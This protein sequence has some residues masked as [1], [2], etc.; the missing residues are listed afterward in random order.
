LTVVART[1]AQPR[2]ARQPK[3]ASA[4]KRIDGFFSDLRAIA[5]TSA[6]RAEL[7]LLLDQALEQLGHLL[8]EVRQHTIIVS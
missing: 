2:A 7:I 6:Q 4:R 5:G 1:N 8:E 3:V